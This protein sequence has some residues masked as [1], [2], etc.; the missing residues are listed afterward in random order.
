M[1][2][3][4]TQ[5]INEEDVESV[6]KVLKSD[7]LTQGPIV[8]LFENKIA[9]MVSSKFAYAMNSATS[10]LHISCLALEL[11]EGDILWTV[12]NS[13]VASANCGLYCGA[14]I[15]FVD[16]DPYTYNISLD[17]LKKKLKHAEDN[18]CL[19]KI[20]VTVDFAGQPVEQEEI[21]KLSKKYN[22]K[23]LEDASHALG[24]KRNDVEIGNN[25]WSDITV[26]SF[27]PVKMITCGEGGMALTQ[28][29]IYAK[30]IDVLRTH[31]ITRDKR[32]F[33]QS[34]DEPWY[35]E[36]IDLGYN[37]RMSDIHATLGLSQLKRLNIF[38]KNRNRIA[39]QYNEALCNLPISL[40]KILNEN[41]SSYHLYVIR[42]NLEEV[43][44]SYNKVFNEL[45]SKGIGV[46][47]HYLP[48]HLH[49]FFSQ[50]GFKK[51]D[52]PQAEK[53]GQEA[54]SLPIFS[55][56]NDNQQSY[57]CEEI[58]KIIGK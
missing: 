44:L 2:P 45:R 7:Y 46:N 6:T 24:S 8:K 47:L 56:L 25:K 12:P 16:I 34:I 37:Y 43:N 53:H 36:Q 26:F 30:R 40:P 39:M 33:N 29:E 9:Q 54:L 49:P 17:A 14:K 35:Y 23:I 3:Y 18:N 15:S 28:N 31:G 1:I 41:Y 11:R 57:I 48:I 42:L 38:L 50:K 55:S 22:F 21:Y 20:L 5:D 4:S 32:Q 52:Y 19:P 27:H 13:F 51:G 10:A 58:K